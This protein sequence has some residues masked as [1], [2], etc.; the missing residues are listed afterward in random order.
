MVVALTSSN[1]A[2]I[3]VLK[4]GWDT[5]EEYVAGGQESVLQAML[6]HHG[7]PW[8]WTGYLVHPST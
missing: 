3:V 8:P 6:W 2:F 5:W 4:L 7:A 1:L